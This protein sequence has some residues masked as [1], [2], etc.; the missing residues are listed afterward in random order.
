MHRRRLAI[1]GV[2]AAALAILAGCGGSEIGAPTAAVAPGTQISAQAYLAAAAA[3]AEA[4]RDFVAALNAAGPRL[5]AARLKARATE[6]DGAL[7][8]AAVAGEQLAAGRLADRRLEEQRQ[9]AV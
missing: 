6:L 9:R 8:R 7:Q 1:L 5:T 3:E 2:L 4:A